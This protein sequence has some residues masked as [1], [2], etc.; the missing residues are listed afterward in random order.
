MRRYLIFVALSLGTLEPQ[1]VDASDSTSEALRRPGRLRDLP[2]RL[3]RS[4][5]AEPVPVRL[6][7]AQGQLTFYGVH[8]VA[9]LEP[10]GTARL[11]A[12]TGE[13]LQGLDACKQPELRLLS[14]DLEFQELCVAPCEAPLTP[15]SVMLGVAPGGRDPRLSDPV[16]VEGGTTII[17]HYRDRRAQRVWGFAAAGV[18]AA[19]GTALLVGAA[20]LD[21]DTS[22]HRDLAIAGAIS[23]G[24]SLS[25]A[26]F[27][28]LMTDEL[29]LETVR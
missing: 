29:D 11:D 19:T 10:C 12:V 18:T 17:A 27:G 3:F 5:E 7:A 1:P 13:V 20:T 9:E 23:L 14:L 24:A 21:P 25:L 4:T 28:A 6:E 8:A 15:G 22:S 16:A 2:V 26:L